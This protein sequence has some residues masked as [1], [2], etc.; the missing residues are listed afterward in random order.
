MLCVVDSISDGDIELK[1]H[2]DGR[3]ATDRGKAKERVR[4]RSRG[5]REG[6]FEKVE[7]TYLGEVRRAGG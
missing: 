6:L 4:L 7:V 5:I 3:T 2:T 1:R